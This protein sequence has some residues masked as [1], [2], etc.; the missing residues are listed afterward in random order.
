MTMPL[1]SN[2]FLLKAAEAATSVVQP[3]ANRLARRKAQDIELELQRRALATTVDF[4]QQQ[5]PHIKGTSSKF[6]LL[7]EAIRR[8]DISEGRLICEFGVFI[9]RL[10]S[11]TVFGFDSF[12]GLPEEWNKKVPQGHFALKSLPAVRSN[13]TLVKGWF[14]ESLPSFL[15]QHAG[16]VGFL[17]IDCDLY[18]STRTVFELL[19]PRLGPGTVIVF[20][21][22]F[23]YPNWEEG[24]HKAF[25]E[26]LDSTGLAAD[27]IGIPPPTRTSRSYLATASALA[28]AERGISIRTWRR[29]RCDGAGD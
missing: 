9:A 16:A 6:D 21:E 19:A 11:N 17:H 3:F 13:V 20:D 5:M 23:N 12:E 14:N 28:S 7:N 24:E 27:Y 18:S 2:R 8:A 26:F 29:R 10:T 1:N 15:A 4:V 25:T 22:Y